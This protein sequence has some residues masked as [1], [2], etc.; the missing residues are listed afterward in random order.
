MKPLVGMLYNP[1]VPAVIDYA[2]DLVQYI[3]VIPDRL[4]Y[5]LG[6]GDASGRRFREV[7][8]AIEELKRCA[9]GRVLAGHGIGL[10]LPSAI[11]LDVPQVEQVARL[12]GD[13]ELQWYSEHLS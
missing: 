10:S 7:R 2:P 9:E 12:A 5:D 4:W 11:P 3:A 1:V 13:L 6:G 8:G